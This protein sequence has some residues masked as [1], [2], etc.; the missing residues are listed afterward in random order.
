M[1]TV[2]GNVDL[3]PTGMIAHA[4][5]SPPHLESGARDAVVSGVGVV[6]DVYVLQ[7]IPPG[8]GGRVHAVGCVRPGRDQ[9]VGQVKELVP[10][11]PDP[12]DHQL[13]VSSKP[14]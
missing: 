13:P 9:E 12:Q 14:G 10:V 3:S 7:Q 5:P 11:L 2:D 4:P 1:V 6:R 8:R